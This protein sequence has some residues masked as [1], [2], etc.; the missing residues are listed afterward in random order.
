MDYFINSDDLKKLNIPYLRYASENFIENLFK[1]LN[2]RG[3][4]MILYEIEAHNG[5]WVCVL[6]KNK[7]HRN[8]EFFDSYGMKT[9]EELKHATYSN[10]MSHGV[11]LLHDLFE[12]TDSII[13]YNGKRL[14][15]M[16]K[17][18][19]TCGKW[20][21]LRIYTMCHFP[22]EAGTLTQ[23]LKYVKKNKITDAVLGKMN[24]E[25]FIY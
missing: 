16:A 5:H 25:D 13:E 2:E 21:I 23:F 6:G 9:D 24:V 10:L 19:N 4:C 11:K 8:L 15:K 7:G 12:N 1:H 22:E 3:F 18:V 17:N 14:Q 20:C